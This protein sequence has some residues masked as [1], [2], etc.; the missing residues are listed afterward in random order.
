MEERCRKLCFT[1]YNI[2]EAKM[3]IF[4]KIMPQRQN[5]YKNL[6]FDEI[7]KKLGKVN[8]K[9]DEPSRLWTLFYF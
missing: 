9:K 1:S 3:A 5:L 7:F 4:E 2:A 8:L 6:K